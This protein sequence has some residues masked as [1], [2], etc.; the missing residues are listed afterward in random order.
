MQIG[1][2]VT[3]FRKITPDPNPLLLD[4]IVTTDDIAFSEQILICFYHQI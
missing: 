1:N 4:E 2:Y 3:I